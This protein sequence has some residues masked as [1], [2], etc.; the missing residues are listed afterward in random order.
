M[1][2]VKLYKLKFT[3]AALMVEEKDT[4]CRIC[5]KLFYDIAT[6][7]RHYKDVHLKLKNAKCPYCDY[8]CSRKT[9]LKT[10]INKIHFK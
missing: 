8:R 6:M 2:T 9:Y 3:D 4:T 5:Y 10:H 1:I 7:K